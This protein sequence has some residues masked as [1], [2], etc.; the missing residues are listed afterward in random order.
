[1]FNA[2]EGEIDFPSAIDP[3]VLIKLKTLVFIIFTLS[4]KNNITL[5]VDIKQLNNQI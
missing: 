2:S 3:S 5:Q 1:M 4:V